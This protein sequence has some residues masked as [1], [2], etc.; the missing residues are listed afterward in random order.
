LTVHK[1]MLVVVVADVEVDE[2][3]RFERLKVGTSP[4]ELRA[5]ADWL[6]EREEALGR[7]GADPQL[8][9]R[10]RATPVAD[11]HAP[12]VSGHAQPRPAP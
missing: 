3:Y 10:R 4:S 8:C 7:A 1:K 2:E 12:Q 5:L 11:R 9:A 6:V